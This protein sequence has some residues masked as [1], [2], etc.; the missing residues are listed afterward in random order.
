MRVIRSTYRG[1]AE[2]L[3]QREVVRAARAVDGTTGEA[4]GLPP[5]EPAVVVSGPDEHAAGAGVLV[6]AVGSDGLALYRR[7]VLPE[8]HGTDGGGTRPEDAVEAAIQEA[9][10]QLVRQVGPPDPDEE[11]VEAAEARGEQSPPLR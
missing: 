3:A 2:W 8:G 1:A 10:R 9:W 11:P 7:L 5:L 4:R 6:E